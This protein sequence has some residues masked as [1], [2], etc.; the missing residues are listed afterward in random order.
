M[1]KEV[2]KKMIQKG[3]I[4]EATDKEL[5]KDVYYMYIYGID[6]P[7]GKK[8]VSSVMKHY[9]NILSNGKKEEA[10][11]AK[12]QIRKLEKINKKEKTGNPLIPITGRK[13]SLNQKQEVLRHIREHGSITSWEAF[14]EY[15]ITRLSAI[16]YKLR[17]KENLS[18]SKIDVTTKNRYNNTV[19]FAKY[20]INESKNI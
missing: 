17:H 13:K 2:I 4:S 20:I 1:K 15:G 14:K 3:V 7:K 8:T 12:S 9:K 18:I 16:I 19:T 5:S 11:H 6:I 10:K